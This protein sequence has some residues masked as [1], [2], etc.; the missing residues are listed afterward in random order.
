MLST[1]SQLVFNNLRKT[2]R[3]RNGPCLLLIALVLCVVTFVQYFNSTMLQ[4][5]AETTKATVVS[6]QVLSNNA[7][8]IIESRSKNISSVSFNGGED[9]ASDQDQNPS[10]TTA[11]V[12]PLNPTPLASPTS[13]PL[14][15]GEKCCYYA[16]ISLN[17]KFTQDFF[18][19]QRKLNKAVTPWK[20]TEYEEWITISRQIFHEDDD[21]F[22]H[23][24]NLT[25]SASSNAPA[26]A[27]DAERHQY[28]RTEWQKFILGGVSG[29]YLR[30]YMTQL[31]THQDDVNGSFR[32]VHDN[33]DLPRILFL[34][35]SISRGIGVETYNMFH[36][37]GIANIHGAPDNCG[38]FERYDSHLTQWLGICT[39]DVIQ[40]NVG[41][42]FHPKR[43]TANS[44]TT[45]QQYKDS[46][47]RIVT[48]LREH[49][50]NADIVVALTTPS[51]YDS[52]DTYPDTATC[53]NYNLFH[54]GGFVTSLNKW[55]R[56]LA[57]KL[58]VT[59]N[60]RYQ[61]IQP[62]LGKYQRPCDVHFKLE[63][64]QHLAKQD[65]GVISNLI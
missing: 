13:S 43:T 63:G 46:I 22:T 21:T 7:Q 27:D 47:V 61:S 29:F 28:C 58:N 2:A 24:S 52:N 25:T 44:S 23:T 57:P 33:P 55:A 49:S 59:I 19:Q 38:G 26:T 14:G 12:D 18:E 35:D 39:W 8:S 1:Q 31:L 3:T 4:N 9:D 40:F 20:G 5:V 42:H 36:P 32:F 51:P 41:M 56:Q 62:F 45:Q 15:V 37:L 11:V 50:P 48:K 64:Y 16:D 6:K 60:D 30:T 10:T 53:K 54:K 17:E 65:W 34:G